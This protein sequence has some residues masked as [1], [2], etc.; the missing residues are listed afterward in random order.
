MDH[1]DCPSLPI[2]ST[3]KNYQREAIIT[4]CRPDSG[5]PYEKQETR[6]MIGRRKRK[7]EICERE[8]LW[9]DTGRD[10]NS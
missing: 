6:T 9:R 10:A 4:L 3:I 1:T 7:D 5:A 2:H 8:I